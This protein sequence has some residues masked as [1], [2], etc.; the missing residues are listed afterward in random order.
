[1][2]VA[3]EVSPTLPPEAPPTVVP[4]EHQVEE[5][6]VARDFDV[7]QLMTLVLAEVDKQPGVAV[8]QICERI[9]DDGDGKV[10]RSMVYQALGRLKATGKVHH[11]LHG[12]YFPA[13]YTE[14]N[15]ELSPNEEEL[16]SDA[17]KCIADNK[18]LTAMEIVRKLCKP[19]KK[20]VAALNHLQEQ[21]KIQVTE[22]KFY[23]V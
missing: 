16:C 7:E 3:E 2:S 8:S 1:M 6:P 17:L 11:T 12:G 19:N 10:M 9:S 5:T 21:G 15:R 23:P 4:E 20:V 14:P 18:G 22:C 13:G